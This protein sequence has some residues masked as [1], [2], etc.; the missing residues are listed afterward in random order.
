M[1]KI[2]SMQF[3]FILN[4]TDI[5]NSEENDYEPYVELV[6]RNLGKPFSKQIKKE[7]ETLKAIDKVDDEDNDDEYTDEM[8][9]NTYDHE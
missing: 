2:V 9:S 4:H 3:D 5:H 6:E 7:I 1:S 8:E